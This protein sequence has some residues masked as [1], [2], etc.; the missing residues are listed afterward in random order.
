VNGITSASLFSLVVDSTSFDTTNFAKYDVG[1]TVVVV[2][3]GISDIDKIRFVVKE[4]DT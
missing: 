2:V 4:D 3:I 1:T